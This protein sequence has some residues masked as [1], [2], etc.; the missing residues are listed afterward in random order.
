MNWDTVVVRLDGMDLGWT[1]RERLYHGGAEFILRDQTRLK[2][3]LKND[4]RG[5]PLLYATRNGMP[6][7][8]SG[9]DPVSMIRVAAA[10]M[11]IAG[12]PQILL[13]VAIGSEANSSGEG[14]ALTAAGIA[15]TLLGL[16]ALAHSFAAM[17]IGSIMGFSETVLLIG[18]KGSPSDFFQELS[19]L[20]LLGWIL[21]RGIGAAHHLDHVRLPIRRP[22]QSLRHD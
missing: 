14:M 21:L 3:W 19:L 1:D 6:L 20:I 4:A 9:G 12:L 18:L 11:L 17:V 15:L 10:I 22:P 8:D 5:Y 16:F 13:G 7:P 2:I